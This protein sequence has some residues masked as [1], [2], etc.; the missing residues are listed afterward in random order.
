MNKITY[1][2]Y[3]KYRK[4]ILKS[5]YMLCDVSEPY[6][7][8]NKKINKPHDKTYKLLLD[9]KQ[10]AVELINKT[11]ELKGTQNEIGA[12]EIEKYS[13]E[14][15][16][17][18]LKSIEADIVYKKKCEDIFFL[19]EHQSKIDYSMPYRLLNYSIE[20]IRSN[21][22]KEKLKNKEYQFPVV[23]PIVLYTGKQK[24]NAKKF[25]EE[26]QA[27]QPGVK[28]Y[29][30]TFYNIVDI[31]NYTD[32][33]L[34][35][36]NQLLPKV[37][38][39]EKSR[40]E[41]KLKKNLEKVIQGEL[42]KDQKSELRKIIIYILKEKIGEEDTKKFVNKLKEEGDDKMSA[43]AEYIWGAIDKKLEEGMQEGI[44][45]GLQ[46]GRI[47]GMKEGMKEGIRKGVKQGKEKIIIK[48]L[49]TKMDEETICAIAEIDRKELNEIKN[50]MKVIKS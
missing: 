49:Q 32:E 41:E 35:E 37:L 29:P 34:L 26:S 17:E 1:L 42:T 7:L 27:K 11:L 8:Q 9:N 44:E 20:I 31:N 50:K 3:L 33:E 48:M 2:D 40:T 13:R 4:I 5:A 23:Y 38:L 24:W 16:T 46:E 47:K 28:N 45:K 39:L 12:S 6:K 14:F 30:F 15:E 10:E 25:F 18:E 21:V 36:G 43:L 22:I 19:I